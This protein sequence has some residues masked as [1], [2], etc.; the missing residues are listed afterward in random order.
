MIDAIDAIEL[1][2]DDDADVDD[3]CCRALPLHRQ[4]D[5]L[6]LAQ[7]LH[8]TGV[9]GTDRLP[10]CPLVGALVY[11][12]R[13]GTQQRRCRPRRGVLYLLDGAGGPVGILYDQKGSAP[14]SPGTRDHRVQRGLNRRRHVVHRCTREQGT[15]LR[16]D[17]VGGAA[18]GDREGL[19]IAESPP[20]ARF[21]GTWGDGKI[22][23]RCGKLSRFHFGGRQ[24]RR[25]IAQHRSV[26]SLRA[27]R[28][29][30]NRD[31]IRD[32]PGRQSTAHLAGHAL[33]CGAAVLAQDQAALGP[34]LQGCRKYQGQRIA[35]RRGVGVGQNLADIEIGEVV[36][37]D[38][39]KGRAAIGGL[40]DTDRAPVG[41]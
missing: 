38:Q 30:G 6:R 18:Y 24:I 37:A 26:E 14:A 39:G 17:R 32:R 7:A 1:C 8:E 23:L 25:T 16:V 31:Q 22:L 41:S 34:V 33:P 27:G 40:E 11:A 19:P 5:P 13:V 3:R 12:A 29:I 36:L 21:V 4:R 20:Q 10:G 9:G 35:G 15:E 28:G 2:A